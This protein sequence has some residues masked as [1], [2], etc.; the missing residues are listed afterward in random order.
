[1]FLKDKHLSYTFHRLVSEDFHCV[2]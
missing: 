2:T 1:L